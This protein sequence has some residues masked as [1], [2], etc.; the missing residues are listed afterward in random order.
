MLLALIRRITE[1]HERPARGARAGARKSSSPVP[2]SPGKNTD[3][4]NGR[5]EGAFARVRL[6]RAWIAAAAAMVALC[7]AFSTL[8]DRVLP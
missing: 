5:Y 4:T 1:E 6:V 8:L 2:S 3:D 7:Y